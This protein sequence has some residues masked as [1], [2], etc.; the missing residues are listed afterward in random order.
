ML[1]FSL[2]KIYG[3][4]SGFRHLNC[5][6]GIETIRRSATYFISRCNECLQLYRD[7]LQSKRRHRKLIL[8]MLEKVRLEGAYHLWRNV[9]SGELSIDP[10]ADERRGWENGLVE[11]S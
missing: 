8:M 1:R 3:F 6:F 11:P 7:H 10:E 9:P 5:A 4:C 2:R